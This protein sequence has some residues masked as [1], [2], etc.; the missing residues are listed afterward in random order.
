MSTPKAPGCLVIRA[1]TTYEGKQGNTFFAGI[2]AES[3]GAQAICMHLITIPPGGRGQVHLHEE[4]ETA[5]YVLSGHGEMWFGE[6][7]Q[8]YVAL[9]VGDFVYIPAGMPHVPGNR[10]QTEPAIAVLART[11]PNEQESVMLL[12]HLEGVSLRRPEDY[13]K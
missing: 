8:D 2:S 1:E 13:Q 5:L 11:D 7:L 12:P 10:S 9:E 4:H 6:H 3:A